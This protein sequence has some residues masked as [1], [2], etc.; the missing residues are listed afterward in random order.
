MPAYYS[1]IVGAHFRPPAKVVLEVLPL[2]TVLYGRAEPENPYDPNAVAVYLDN[3]LEALRAVGPPDSF[4][5]E[6]F[7]GQLLNCG[8]SRDLLAKEES[9]QLGY[10]SREQN[11]TFVSFRELYGAS[12]L[13]NEQAAEKFGH[14]FMGQFLR[15]PSDEPI[16]VLKSES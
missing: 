12:A 10:L 4:A 5:W 11:K 3:P 1:L 6:L 2:N 16:L 15:G 7:E 8:W 13:S 9:L 14:E